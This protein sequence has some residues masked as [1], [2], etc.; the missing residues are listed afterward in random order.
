[1]DNL[2]R[3]KMKKIFLAVLIISSVAVTSAQ[4]KDTS[5]KYWITIG[6]GFWP[7]QDL[8][9]NINYSFSPNFSF[10]S[11]DNFF[12]VEYFSKGGFSFSKNI[13]VGKDGFLYNTINLSIGKRILSDWFMACLFLG[14]SYVFGEKRTPYGPYE[15]FKT[16]GVGSD[17][18]LLF[19][20]A[21]EIGIGVGLYGNLNFANNY[22]GINININLGNGK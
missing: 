20:L 7:E 9:F 5:Y 1:M 11:D 14:P 13:E 22:V 19:R 6:G 17:I 10:L 21:N 8:S 3:G 15:K 12:K 4:D 2:K 16:I 18:Q